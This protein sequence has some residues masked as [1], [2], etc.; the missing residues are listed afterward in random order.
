MKKKLIIA[1]VSALFIAITCMYA[2]PHRRPGPPPPGS[3]HP[4]PPP[5][6]HHHPVPPRGHVSI[7]I[8]TRPITIYRSSRVYVEPVCTRRHVA[9]DPIVIYNEDDLYETV[10]YPITGTITAVDSTRGTIVLDSDGETVVVAASASTKILKD[11]DFYDKSKNKV[12]GCVSIEIGDIHK[13]DFVGISVTDE[14][15]VILD[16]SVVHVFDLSD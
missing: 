2:E 4:A 12:K 8:R 1:V 9:E 15:E 3:H 5:P 11:E 10:E 7:R 6:K 14:G 13:G 16:A